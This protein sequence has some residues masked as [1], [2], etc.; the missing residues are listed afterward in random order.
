MKGHGNMNEMVSVVL[1][2]CNEKFLNKTIKGLI[3]NAWG[4]IEIIPHIDVDKPIDDIIEHECVIPIYSHPKV[5]MREGINKGVRKARG[6]FIMKLDAHCL[7]GEGYDVKLKMSCEDNML[8]VPQRFQLIDEPWSRGY[9]KPDQLYITPPYNKPKD[10]PP[11]KNDRWE[12]GIKGKEWKNFY[13]L[14]PEEKEKPIMDLMTFQGSCYFM[15]RDYYLSF[16]GL[17]T[18]FFGTFRREAQEIGCKVWL[19]GGRV[20]RNKLAWYAHLHKGKKYGRGYYLSWSEMQKG[21]EA[22][23]DL[24]MNDGWEGQTRPFKWLVEKFDP[25]EWDKYNW[26]TGRMED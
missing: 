23:R 6:K 4:E 24:W 2:A 14:R 20:V 13:D 22:A 15:H 18:N 8:M 19:S 16:G 17:D 5:G 12:R 3:D 10:I 21:D 25:P 7:V 26:E 11:E 1:P 9:L